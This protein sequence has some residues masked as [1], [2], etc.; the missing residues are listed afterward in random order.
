MT[1]EDAGNEN[2]NDEAGNEGNA[3]YLGSWKT[4]ESAEEG[5]KNLESKLGSQ[6]NELGYL[7]QQVELTQQIINDL[8]SQPAATPSADGAPDY[9]KEMGAIQKEMATLDPVDNNYQKDLALLVQKSNSL[10]AQIAHEKTLSV[11]TAAFKKELDDRDVKATH[12][13]FY[14]KNPDFN[15]P[16]MQMRIKDYIARDTT[17]M[18]DPLVAYREIQR[19][20]AAQRARE[21]ETENAE[22]KKLADLAKGTAST[23][24]V[25]TKGQSLQQQTKQSKATGADLDKGMQEALSRL[26]E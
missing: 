7:R 26:R 6:G 24:K 18:S 4:R 19:D 3:P 14:E 21:L 11:A 8:K 2:V 15:T 12:K 9:D 10:A 1:T 13:S 25:V 17:G 16:E 20:T 23:G 5:V 22:L